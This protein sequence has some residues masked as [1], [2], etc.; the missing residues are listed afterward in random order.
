VIEPIS[1]GALDPAS[2]RAVPTGTTARPRILDEIARS[3][4]VLDAGMG[5]RLIRAGLDLQNDD[6]ALWCLSHPEAIVAIHR[7]DLAS[8]A[9]AVLTNTF[10]ANRSWLARFGQA[11]HVDSINRR[12]VELARSAAGP[13]RFVVGSVGPT[14]GKEP[15]AAA[16]QALVLVDEG[17]DALLLE[18]YR[19]PEIESVLEEVTAALPVHEP[20]PVFVSLWE[21]PE[22][23]RS[24][25]DRLVERGAAVLGINCQ[26]GATAAVAFAER[27]G[28]TARVPLLVKPGVGTRPEEA[29]SP[30]ELAAVV[31]RLMAHNVRLIGGC[32]GTDEHHVA[33]VADR[34]R[35]HRVSFRYK[36][37]DTK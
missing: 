17:V 33:A 11:D 2:P 37:G 29:M 13:G 10:S 19:L 25:A 3:T 12:A 4:L 36:T 14:A 20:V 32:C 18:T 24:A 15:G 6:P 5:T 1:P 7:L 27:L 26:P 28:T 8:G 23:P 34:V 16:E 35:I 21:W 30:A 22:K 9:D 31:S